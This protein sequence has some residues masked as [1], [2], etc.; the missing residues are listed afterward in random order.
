MVPFGIERPWRNV[1]YVVVIEGKAD[2]TQTLNIVLTHT[3][4]RSDLSVD[5]LPKQ[6]HDQLLLCFRLG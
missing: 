3:G 2:L 5:V 1:W 6:L 4:L